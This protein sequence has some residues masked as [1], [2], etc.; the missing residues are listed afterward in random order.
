MRALWYIS[1]RV[2]TT[3][4]PVALTAVLNPL[5]AMARS[6]A[7]ATMHT[8][9]SVDALSSTSGHQRAPFR[10]SFWDAWRMRSAALLRKVTSKGRPDRAQVIVLADL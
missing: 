5:S 4:P 1:N 10:L 2:S 8:T 7:A 9:S 3:N 6:H